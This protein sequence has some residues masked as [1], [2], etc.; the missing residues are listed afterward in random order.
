MRVPWDIKL[1]KNKHMKN[2][3][4]LTALVLLGMML[5][6]G[7]SQAQTYVYTTFEGQAYEF[8]AD[9]STLPGYRE[10]A[11][12]GRFAQ[13]FMTHPANDVLSE[14]QEL[15][16]TWS[17]YGQPVTGYYA[18]DN[19][20]ITFDRGASR[21]FPANTAIPSAAEPNDAIYVFWDDWALLEGHPMSN[22]VLNMTMG[23]APN[24]THLVMWGGISVA[25]HPFGN[26]NTTSFF[27]ALHE[28]GD[29]DIAF[30]AS[31]KPATM[32]GTIGVENF[33]GSIA[34]M[35]S[36]SPNIDFPALTP[37]PSDMVYYE[38]RYTDLTHGARVTTTDL[39]DIVVKN[40]EVFISGSLQNEGM[41]T[42]S[43]Y[44]L[45]YQV[46]QA[47]PVRTTIRGVSI[48]SSE[49]SQFTHNIG[50]KPLEAGKMYQ[51]KVWI[52]NINGVQTAAGQTIQPYVKPVFAHLGKS[53]DK[54]VLVEQFTGTWCV[55]CPDGSVQM[56]LIEKQHEDAVLI[57]IH[58]GG[59][60]QMIVPEGQQISDLYTPSF[61]MAM[62]DRYK[63]DPS[64]VTVPM[65]RTQNA[66]LKATAERNQHITPVKVKIDK[67][68]DANSRTINAT[69][70]ADFIDFAYPGDLRIHFM[71]VEDRVVGEGRG[72]DQSNAFSNNQ[73][74]P[75][76]IY[77]SEPNPIPGY[78]HRNVL[79]AV[80]SG[81]EGTPRVISNAP[82]PGD[83][84][85]RTYSY[86]LP[87]GY[88]EKEISLVAFVAYHDDARVAERFVLNAT[89]VKLVK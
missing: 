24:R 55:W 2:K 81:A 22:R 39:P 84:F 62:V 43:S 67:N 49:I 69:V 13:P 52:E 82:A 41:E 12:P 15:P 74:F 57:A 10:G 75:N 68:Y 11:H 5:M 70:T 3:H 6:G 65:G 23:V 76:H 53:A 87:E 44:D 64:S 66:W 71:V 77:F 28:N 20:Y 21:S 50:W 18:S 38:F 63:F 42:I 48:G 26:N 33:D 17:F 58:A 85:S 80:P 30:M 83:S 56:S 14:W 60:D 86:T 4:F 73:S 61:P 54:R 32:S 89:E 19:G 7:M 16:F 45:V 31:R 37:A 36:G 35:V 25:G 40:K 79:R 78:V 1:K 51:L 88:N 9:P 72:Y 46:D 27:L 34:T 29:F 59:N 8:R 47:N